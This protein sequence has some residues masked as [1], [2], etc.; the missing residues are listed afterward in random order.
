MIFTAVPKIYEIKNFI[1]KLFF[2]F[3]IP[4]NYKKKISLGISIEISDK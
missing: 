2:L 3:R 4:K 1:S